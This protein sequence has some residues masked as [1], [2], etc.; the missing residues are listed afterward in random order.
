V[1]LHLLQRH[2]AVVVEAPHRHEQ[3]LIGAIDRPAHRYQDASH[4]RVHRMPP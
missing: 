4:L 3:E 1:L 2:P